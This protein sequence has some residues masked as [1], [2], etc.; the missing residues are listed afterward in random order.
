MSQN[1][2]ERLKKDIEDLENYASRLKK[3]G[4]KDLLSKIQDK[5]NYLRNHVEGATQ[6]AL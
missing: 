5:C 1:Q 3:R 6:Q 4:Q 2:V